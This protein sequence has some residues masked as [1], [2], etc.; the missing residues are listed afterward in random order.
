MAEPSA[1]GDKILVS[2]WDY[3][4]AANLFSGQN[5][6]HD[7]GAQ[8]SPATFLV[9]QALLEPSAE[10]ASQTLK[11]LAATGYQRTLQIR[12]NDGSVTAEEQSRLADQQVYLLL[13]EDMSNW[14]GSISTIGFFDIRSGRPLTFNGSSVLRYEPFD[15][16]TSE[17]GLACNGNRF[18]GETGRYGNAQVAGI[19][20]TEQGKVVSGKQFDNP[21]TPY[22]I[23]AE[24]AAG[25]G[26]NLAVNKR[27]FVSVFNQMYHL[28]QVDERYF[29]LVYDDYPHARI[30]SLK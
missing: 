11:L 25:I 30:F 24:T 6:V 27:L 22:F 19:I 20:Y 15:C 7:G 10:K 4:Y 2:W 13:T 8:T 9:A 21:T 3:G 23:Q 29:S 28:G 14:M 26:Q 18:D 1:D 16:I 17:G 12:Y 5:V